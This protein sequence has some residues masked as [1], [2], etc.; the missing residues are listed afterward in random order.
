MKT[1]PSEKIVTLIH[2]LKIRAQNGDAE[3]VEILRAIGWQAAAALQSLAFWSGPDSL[4][5]VRKVSEKSLSWPINYHVMPDARKDF[6][7]PE[8]V[9]DQ[10]N[11]GGKTG[12]KLR[13]TSKH[14]QLEPHH[15]TGWAFY[16]FSMMQRE[17][18]SLTAET[19]LQF[20][21]NH[22]EIQV[23]PESIHRRASKPNHSLES[24][25]RDAFESALDSLK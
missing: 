2:A 25:I 12:W 4:A 11:L 16:V 3:A 21:R 19:A 23:A 22:P 9:C 6:E 18:L 5:A 8:D 15:P 13:P 20:I 7:D 10:I 14:R 17:G 24:A 1:D